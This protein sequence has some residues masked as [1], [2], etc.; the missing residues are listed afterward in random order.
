MDVGRTLR[1]DELLKELMRA[2][3]WHGEVTGDYE[4]DFVNKEGWYSRLKRQIENE[5]QMP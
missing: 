4:M 2:A 3:Y 5:R 1:M